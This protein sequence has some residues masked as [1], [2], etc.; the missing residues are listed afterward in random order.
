MLRNS[1]KIKGG[2]DKNMLKRMLQY[3]YDVHN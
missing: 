1:G 3:Y 2:V